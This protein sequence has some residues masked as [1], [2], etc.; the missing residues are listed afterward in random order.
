MLET[1]PA[2][3]PSRRDQ[4]AP[5]GAPGLVGAS[6]SMVVKMNPEKSRALNWHLTHIREAIAS[7]WDALATGKLDVAQR[8]SVREHLNMNQAALRDLTGRNRAIS[9]TEEC[10]AYDSGEQR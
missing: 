1:V 8:K 4:T 5:A 2:A 6:R 3:D 10:V 9:V 7:D